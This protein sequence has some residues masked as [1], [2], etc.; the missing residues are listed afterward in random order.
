MKTTKTV[1]A[2]KTVKTTKSTQVAQDSINWNAKYYRERAARF[3][4]TASYSA[5]SEPIVVKTTKKEIKQVLQA[6]TKVRHN[7]PSTPVAQPKKFVVINGVPHKF[8][9]GKL[10]AL[11]AVSAE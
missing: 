8:K 7:R 2:A 9:D 1:K 11:T 4:E 5:S 3:Y 6:A 10:V